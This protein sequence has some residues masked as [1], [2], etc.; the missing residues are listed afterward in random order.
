MDRQDK[1]LAKRQIAP[2]ES[3]FWDLFAVLEN[4]SVAEDVEM[5]CVEWPLRLQ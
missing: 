3:E 4:K 1:I 2:D 5:D